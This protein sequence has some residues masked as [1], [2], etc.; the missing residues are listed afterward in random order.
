MAPREQV[1]HMPAATYFNL[2]AT[3][4]KKNGNGQ[5]LSSANKY[6]VHF[7]TG[8]F[9][10]VNGFWSLTMYSVEYFCVG[11]PL[12]RYTLSQR[13]KFNLDP[14]R[15]VDLYLQHQP[16]AGNLV[17]NWLPAP[18]RDFALIL[19]IYWPKKP[20]LKGSWEPPPVVRAQ[21]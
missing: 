11:N 16:P 8:K 17:A 12:N 9:P 3:L 5:R 14:D 7:D 15:W 4:M 20:V 13:N 19:R 6:R 2:L 10:L 21:R 1:N 18:A